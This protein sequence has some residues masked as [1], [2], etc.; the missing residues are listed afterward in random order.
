MV[1]RGG[2][3]AAAIR[4]VQEPYPWVPVRQRHGE[5]LLGQ[6]HGQPVSHRAA[7]H[8]ARVEIEDHG[9]IE[10]TIRCK[11]VGDVTGPYPVRMRHLN[12]RLRVFSATGQPLIRP[13]GGSPLLHGLGPNLFD[14][15]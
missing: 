8:E 10:P 4:V 7:D 6:L 2:I 14:A 11:Y 5:S 9:E 13:S 15:H 1:P 12:W 3:L